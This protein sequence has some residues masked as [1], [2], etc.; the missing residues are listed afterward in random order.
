MLGCCAEARTQMKSDDSIPNVAELFRPALERVAL[1]QRPLLIA[2]AERLAADRYRG[3]ANAAGAESARA[4][5]LACAVR[6][7][8]IASRVEA[9]HA[10]AEAIQ[11]EILEK[12]P[13]LQQLS[14]SLFEGRPVSQQYA[15]QAQGERLGA[16]TWRSIA[17]QQTD[18]SVREVYLACAVLE[19][20]SAGVL[21]TLL[22]AE[23]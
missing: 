22:N 16:A 8:D 4:Q 20:E 23:P 15:I 13:D 9:L 10:S 14:R 5:L 21:E 17:Q 12:N 1:E 11:R 7:E 2:L 19:E 18:P 6:E 3:W